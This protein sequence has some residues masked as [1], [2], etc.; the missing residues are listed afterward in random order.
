MASLATEGAWEGALQ[1]LI[2]DWTS[3]KGHISD[4]VD[5]LAVTYDRNNNQILLSYAIVTSDAEDNSV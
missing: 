1:I 3:L 4:Q 5:L 2:V